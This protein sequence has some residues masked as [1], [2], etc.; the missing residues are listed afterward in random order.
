VVAAA[1][2]AALAVARGATDRVDRIGDAR[3]SLALEVMTERLARVRGDRLGD[4]TVIDRATT[5]TM[6]TSGL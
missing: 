3:V 6:T 4:C 1:A 5:A 2:V